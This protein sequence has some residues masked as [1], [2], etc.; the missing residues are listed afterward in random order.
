M[1]FH[2]VAMMSSAEHSFSCTHPPTKAVVYADHLTKPGVCSES[3]LRELTA[4]TGHLRTTAKV[5]T[6]PRLSSH[7]SRNKWFPSNDSFRC[8][9][10]LTVTISKA[11]IAGASTNTEYGKLLTVVISSALF[12]KF[13]GLEHPNGRMVLITRAIAANSWC[14]KPV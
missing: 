12:A 1:L 13:D 9:T 8:P 11:C 4:L 2:G 14:I 6:V 3:L 10:L 7:H 5:R